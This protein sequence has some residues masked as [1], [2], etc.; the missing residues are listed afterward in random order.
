MTLKYCCHPS[1]VPLKTSNWLNAE[2][3]L[4]D[5]LRYIHNQKILHNDIKS[6]NIVMVKE[7]NEELLDSPI[8]GDFGKSKH[9][10]EL[11][12]KQ[13]TERE[14]E[15]YRKRHFH[16]APEVIEG[17]HAPSVKSDVYSIGLVSY[18]VYKL[19]K[20]KNLK[21]LCTTCLALY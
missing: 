17:L 19:V 3:Q 11:R 13:L 10:S 1:S 6:D 5:A 7:E 2:V 15:I 9:L 20:V 14:K 4:C 12:K 16:V 21:D 18:R 8:L